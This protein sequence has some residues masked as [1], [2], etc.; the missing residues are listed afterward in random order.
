MSIKNNLQ[1]K[2]KEYYMQEKN[3]LKMS[4]TKKIQL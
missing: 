1:K 4:N 3:T 2:I